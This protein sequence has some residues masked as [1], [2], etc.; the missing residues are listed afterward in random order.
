MIFWI[1]SYPKSGNTW[2]RALLSS[3]FYS[4]D[5]IFDQK[6]LENIDQFPE[7]KYFKSFKYDPK[8]IT[9]TSKFWIKAQ[10]LINKDNK[11][12]FLKTHNILGAIDNNKFTNKKNTLGAI[13][14]V[15][16]PRNIIT[17][18]QNH[19]ELDKDEAL[20]FILNEKKYIYDFRSQGNYSDFQFISS[21]EKNY[22]S[23]MLQNIFPIKII[24]Y[25]DLTTK[26]YDVFYQVI[27]FIENVNGSNKKFNK[28]KAINSINSTTFEKMRKL[29]KNFGFKE[30]ILS[31]NFPVKIPFFHLGPKNDWK[32]IFDKN[33][34]NKINSI[35]KTN[36]EELDYIN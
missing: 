32:I 6:L 7:K 16:D 8:V 22:K 10:E 19:Y 29:E 12:K 26:T 3:Y 30:S 27:K 5:G 13:Y 17:S 21:W 18:L 24:K 11:L 28:L 35:F 1:A 2:L 9:D 34:Q 33:Y 20:K 25:E 4:E 14:I 15:R 36:L 31:K 23:W